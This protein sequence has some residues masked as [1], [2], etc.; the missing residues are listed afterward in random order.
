MAAQDEQLDVLMDRLSREHVQQQQALREESAASVKRAREEASTQ[1]A[2]LSEHLEARP[3]L[4]RRR[5]R[6]SCYAV[7]LLPVRCPEV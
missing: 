5:A 3:Q 7:S 6:L 1:A 2:R 4:R